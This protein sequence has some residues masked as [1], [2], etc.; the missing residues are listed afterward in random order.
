MQR[1][2]C[3]TASPEASPEFLAVSDFV[4]HC[5]LDPKLLEL[6]FLRASQINGCSWCLE[7][8]SRRILYAGETQ[9]RL[10]LLAG[11]R[12]APV[13]PPKERVLSVGIGIRTGSRKANVA[14]GGKFDS[15]LWRANSITSSHKRN[16]RSQIERVFQRLESTTKS[17]LRR[18]SK[19][20]PA[21]PRSM[22]RK[23]KPRS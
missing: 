4:H 2:N 9:Q 7:F 8:N 11:W 16:I 17:N 21:G 10:N 19:R 23:V 15:V 18:S 22:W 14:T 12:D 6:I 1:L 5:G 13:Y 20:I 3:A